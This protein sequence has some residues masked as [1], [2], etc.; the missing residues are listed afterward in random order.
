MR[1]KLDWLDREVISFKGCM[2]ENFFDTISS[3]GFI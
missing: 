2:E 1:L 3:H